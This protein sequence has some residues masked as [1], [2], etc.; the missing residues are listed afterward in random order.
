LRRASLFPSTPVKDQKSQNARNSG[1]LEVGFLPSFYWIHDGYQDE[2]VSEP[3][4]V[5]VNLVGVRC[6]ESELDFG[7]ASKRFARRGPSFGFAMA[8]PS[9]CTIHMAKG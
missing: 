4:S 9:T 6:Y 5:P 3:G 7:T 2:C 1:C 8:S